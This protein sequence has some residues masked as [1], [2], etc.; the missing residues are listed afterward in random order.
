MTKLSRRKTILGMGL[1]A[2]GT[3][4]TFSS[5][6]FQNSTTPS[7]DLRVVVEESLNFAGNPD[8][9][10]DLEDFDPEEDNIVNVDEGDSFFD[11]DDIADGDGE[12]FEDIDT[13]LAA[14]N[15]GANEGLEIFAVAGIGNEATFEELFVLENEL[16]EPVAVGIAYD[17]GNE[18]FA[19]DAAPNVGQYG[20][21]IVFE[22]TDSL[23][24]TIPRSAYRFEANSFGDDSVPGQ[25]N[26]LGDG[27]NNLISPAENAD[28]GVLDGET[29]NESSATF[30]GE[31]NGIGDFND[32]PA[33][34]IILQPGQEVTIDLV[35]DIRFDEDVEDVIRSAAGISLDG[36]GTERATVDLLDGITVGTLAGEPSDD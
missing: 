29:P 34:A 6:A 21:D 24:P 3:G 17:R 19:T 15:L 9:G 18:D 23:L 22:G 30:V 20:D 16:T 13:P 2:A 11:G 35:V 26:F 1:L 33:N 5:A 14:T 25:N 32:R 27:T 36:F 28:G 4:A 7:A 10:V 12:V 8:A 31:D